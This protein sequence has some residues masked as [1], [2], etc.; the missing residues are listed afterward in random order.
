MRAWL[1]VE[2]SSSARSVGRELPSVL[3][4]KSPVG[5]YFRAEGT[6]LI[7]RRSEVL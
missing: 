6:G 1:A 4:L 3:E 2:L 5:P 7:S